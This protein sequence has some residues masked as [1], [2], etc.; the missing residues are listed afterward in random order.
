MS[1]YNWQGEWVPVLSPMNTH[2]IINLPKRDAMGVPN[3]ANTIIVE[4][5]WDPHEGPTI[6]TQNCARWLWDQGCDMETFMIY[7]NR[8]V[9]GNNKD[10]LIIYEL[11]PN[12]LL[13]SIEAQERV[14]G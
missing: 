4:A 10:N 8:L 14:R 3:Y 7:W 1:I 5:I 9:D 12:S 11:S 2:K 13:L 6:I